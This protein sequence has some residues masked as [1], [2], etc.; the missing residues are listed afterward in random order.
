MIIKRIFLVLN[1]VE[2][3]QVYGFVEKNQGFEEPNG[4]TFTAC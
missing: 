3:N 2:F 1:F 4:Y